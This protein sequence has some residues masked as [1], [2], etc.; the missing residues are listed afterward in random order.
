MM[1]LVEIDLKNMEILK[2]KICQEI[3]EEY[4]SKLN[5]LE[6]EIHELKSAHLLELRLIQSQFEENL[7]NLKELYESQRIA[8]EQRLLEEH[9]R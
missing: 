2:I 7:K 3:E 6:N 8:L 9:E 5:D 4:K 1:F